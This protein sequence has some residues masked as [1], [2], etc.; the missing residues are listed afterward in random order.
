ME[1][2]L[3]LEIYLRLWKTSNTQMKTAPLLKRVPHPFIQVHQRLPLSK[4]PGTLD[5]TGS[6]LRQTAQ[7]IPDPEERGGALGQ[8]SEQQEGCLLPIHQ[9]HRGLESP[10][11]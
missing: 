10:R 9:R 6:R 3:Y 7:R 5:Q 11:G 2:N 4:Y 1:C 8:H